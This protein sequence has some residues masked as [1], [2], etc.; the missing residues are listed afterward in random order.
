MLNII[1]YKFVVLVIEGKFCVL[2]ETWNKKKE[3]KKQ[4]EKE[5]KNKKERYFALN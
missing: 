3:A 2:R 5:I 1:K 4:G